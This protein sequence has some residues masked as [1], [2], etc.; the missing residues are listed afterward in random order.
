LGIYCQHAYAHTHSDNSQAFPAILKGADMAVYTVFSALGLK[1]QVRAILDTDT[2]EFEDYYE[3][4]EENTQEYHHDPYSGCYTQ[5]YVQPPLLTH[6]VVGT[7]GGH[8]ISQVIA[9]GGNL[10]DVVQTWSDDYRKV[11]W[12]NKPRQSDLDVTHVTVSDPYQCCKPE[13]NNSQYGN[14][15]GIGALY[16]RAAILVEVLPVSQR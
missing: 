8:G 12:V 7:L 1:L 2:Q 15:P 14:E 5:R 10:E 9:D 13:T 3:C 6:D 4:Y 11:L 16:S